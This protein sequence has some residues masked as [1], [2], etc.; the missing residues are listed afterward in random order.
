MRTK[1]RQ[2]GFSIVISAM[3]GLLVAVVVHG[4]GWTVDFFEERQERSEISNFLQKMEREVFDD[5]SIVKM[6]EATTAAGISPTP[7]LNSV[8]FQIFSDSLDSFYLLMSANTNHISPDERYDILQHISTTQRLLA[9]LNNA[10]RVPTDKTLYRGFFE[11]LR[12][13]AQWLK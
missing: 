8:R 4:V 13:K 3:T 12:Q 6:V 11:D 10:N 2:H 5:A 7:D 1:L 9:L